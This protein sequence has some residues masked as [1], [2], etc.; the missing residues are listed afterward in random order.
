VVV[1]FCPPL[2]SHLRRVSLKRNLWF[3]SGLQRSLV[4]FSYCCRLG[5]DHVGHVIEQNCSLHGGREAKEKVGRDRKKEYSIPFIVSR[6][7]RRKWGGSKIGV[8]WGRA[9][10]TLWG[11]VPVDLFPPTRRHFLK[12]PLL[13]I[14]VYS[15]D[16]RPHSAVTSQSPPSEYHQS[17][18]QAD[19]VG[20]QKILEDPQNPNKNNTAHKEQ[21]LN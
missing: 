17:G 2:K 6:K 11:R 9:Q 3:S 14:A 20:T 16:Q 15:R 18:N 21:E 10:Y 12:F 4:T 13:P 5:A 7:Q 1:S 8:G 19:T